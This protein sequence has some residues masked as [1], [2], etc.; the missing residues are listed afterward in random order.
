MAAADNWGPTQCH[1]ALGLIGGALY[2]ESRAFGC[3]TSPQGDYGCGV[4][5]N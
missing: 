3:R 2:K 4:H 5:A 1:G